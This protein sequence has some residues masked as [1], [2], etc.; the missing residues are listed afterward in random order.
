ML[1][2]HAGARCAPPTGAVVIEALVLTGFLG[3]GKTTLLGHLLR[4]P[5]F[6]HTA[7]IINEFGEVGLDHDLIEASEDSLIELAT[8]CLCC[9]LRNDIATTIHDLLWRRDQGKVTPFSR[10]V[11]ETSGLADPAPILQTLMTDPTIAA[12]I[13]VAGVVATVDAVNGSDTLFREGISIKQVALADRLVVTKAD[14]ANGEQFSLVRRM[15]A[16][17][18]TA[19]IFYAN[20]GEIDARCLFDGTLHDALL[21]SLDVRLRLDTSA[22]A[23]DH[24]D[25]GHD[26]NTF[27]ILR[28]E[29]IRAV[30]LT[31]L[32]EALSDHCGADLLRLKGIVNILESP[33]QP[34]VIHGVQHVFHPPSWLPRWPSDDRRSRI[35]FITRSVPRRWVEVLLDAIDAEVAAASSGQ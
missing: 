13:A 8:G 3:S 15:R 18:A 6:S 21:E 24:A 29:P 16:L 2:T 30:A 20:Y 32:L 5:Q 33:D 19:P 31:L 4:Q 35:V 10:V 17:N 7:V 27:T 11:I 1:R 28:G 9:K 22:I 23:S 12:R 14:L 25:G 34:A 26:V